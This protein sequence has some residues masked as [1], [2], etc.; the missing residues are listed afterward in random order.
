M[1]KSEL[2]KLIRQV[3]RE[4]DDRPHNWRELPGYNPDAFYGDDFKKMKQKYDSTASGGVFDD[5]EAE[6]MSNA[7]IGKLQQVMGSNSLSK[8][9]ITLSVLAD[10]GGMHDEAQMIKDLGSKL[11]MNESRGMLREGYTQQEGD[12]LCSGQFGGGSTMS[13]YNC[14][15]QPPSYECTIYCTSTVPGQPPIPFTVAGETT[16]DTSPVREPMTRG[17]DM[18]SFDKPIRR[19][20]FR[21]GSCGYTQTPDGRKLKTPGGTKGRDAYQ[22]TRGMSRS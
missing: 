19:K 16:V 1:K 6:S 13:H 3:I 11:V 20:D 17:N 18:W 9:L 7:N 12:A 2:K 10:K 5:E 8:I 15:N 14:T 4:Q 21:E 22:R